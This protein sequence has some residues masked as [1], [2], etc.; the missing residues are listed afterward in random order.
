[1]GPWRLMLCESDAH[2]A[3]TLLQ[4]FM[5]HASDSWIIIAHSDL[6]LVTKHGGRF[7]TQMLTAR[8]LVAVA[9]R[10][11]LTESDAVRSHLN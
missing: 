7:R 2:A 9:P 10:A 4:T 11:P 5:F 1:M 3:V 8:L 6:T